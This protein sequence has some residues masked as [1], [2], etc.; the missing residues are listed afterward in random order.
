[1]VYYGNSVW[2]GIQE[3]FLY[4]EMKGFLLSVIPVSQSIKYDLHELFSQNLDFPY[5]GMQSQQ[6]AC[7][8]LFQIS[9][10][11]C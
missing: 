1:M 2:W 8:G 4:Q 6:K 9:K 3:Q 5:N 7:F 10:Q 11:K